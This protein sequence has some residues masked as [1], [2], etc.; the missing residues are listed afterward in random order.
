MNAKNLASCLASTPGPQHMAHELT[1]VHSVDIFLSA[2]RNHG[3]TARK[4]CYLCIGGR[5]GSGRFTSEINS[6]GEN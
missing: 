1:A 3:I 5:V 6:V 2:S 4:V